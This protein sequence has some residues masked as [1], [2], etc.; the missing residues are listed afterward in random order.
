MEKSKQK[1]CRFYIDLDADH[2]TDTELDPNR[3]V[4]VNKKKVTW[5]LDKNEVREFDEEEQMRMVRSRHSSESGDTDEDVLFVSDVEK[6]PELQ[7]ELGFL[8]MDALSLLLNGNS[9]NAG[10]FPESCGY[11]FD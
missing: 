4:K 9:Q 11:I 3:P 7:E 8:V 6:I 10:R 1:N 2:S 5:K